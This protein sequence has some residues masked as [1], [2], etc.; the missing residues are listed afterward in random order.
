[1]LHSLTRSESPFACSLC[2]MHFSLELH[3]IMILI[4]QDD[5]KKQYHNNDKGRNHVQLW[6]EMHRAT[7]ACK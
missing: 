1:M 4:Y 3:N 5:I 7:R 6:T 2:S